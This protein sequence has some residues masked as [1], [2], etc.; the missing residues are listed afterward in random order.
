MK[1]AIVPAQITTVEDK[2]TGSLSLSQLLLLATPV[3]GGSAIYI[4]FPPVL[5]TSLLKIVLVTI[6][7]VVCSL[8]AIRIKGQILLI[9]AIILLRYNTRP[10]FYVFNKN[11]LYLRIVPKILPKQASAKKA[12]R[13]KQEKTATESQVNIADVVKLEQLMAHPEAKLHFV[14]DRKGALSVRI[15][16]VK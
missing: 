1:T 11:D 16:E 6:L 2:V 8:F 13:V 10:R 12:V 15:T 7:T 9:W 4:L 5:S 14:T 3:F